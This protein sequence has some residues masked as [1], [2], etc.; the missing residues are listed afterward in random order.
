MATS[1]K[2]AL[3]YFYTNFLSVTDNSLIRSK[4]R[5]STVLLHKQLLFPTKKSQWL[6][7]LGH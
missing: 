3:S 2:L 7:T 5:V 6:Q 1:M 4:E